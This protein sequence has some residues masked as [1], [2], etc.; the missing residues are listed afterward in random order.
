[1]IKRRENP[2]KVFLRR[3]I[4]LSGRVDALSRAIN[5]AMERAFNTGVS[6]KEIVVMNSPAE[7]DPM[8][9]DVCSAVD[10]CEILYQEK[11]K[12]EAALRE[13]L[14]AVDSLKDER[15][16]EILTMRYL[17]GDSFQKIMEKI[18]Y[19]QTQTF[20]IHGRALIEI[21]KWLQGRG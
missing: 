11:A 3:Y 6:V 13:I 9:R 17:C 1:M 21:N 16:K 19:E 18:G 10:A 2:A 5:Q 15:Q 7:H 4:A 8:A 20:V 12:A 14:A